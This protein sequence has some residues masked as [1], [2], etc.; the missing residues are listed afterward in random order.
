M[1]QH[2]TAQHS[3]GHN[4]KHGSTTS[5]QYSVTGTGMPWAAMDIRA[6]SV[7]CLQALCRPCVFLWVTGG[8]G[9]TLVLPSPVALSRCVWIRTV[10]TPIPP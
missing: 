10:L 6:L 9:G 1:T 5:C 3:A 8:G 4:K 2:S 7:H